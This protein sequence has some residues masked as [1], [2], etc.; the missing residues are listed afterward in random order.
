MGSTDSSRC[1]KIDLVQTPENLSDLYEIFQVMGFIGRHVCLVK[2]YKYVQQNSIMLQHL[3]PLHDTTS[4]TAQGEQTN[5]TTLR[6]PF[7]TSLRFATGNRSVSDPSRMVKNCSIH[8]WCGPVSSFFCMENKDFSVK[9]PPV[10]CSFSLH[11]R[12]CELSDV[13]G[14]ASPSNR[15]QRATRSVQRAGKFLS[16]E[17]VPFVRARRQRLSSM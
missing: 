8:V 11:S 7:A 3:D 14:C 17:L 6:R 12:P 1:C 2:L 15:T 16:S 9:T 10:G 4:L 13:G 5:F